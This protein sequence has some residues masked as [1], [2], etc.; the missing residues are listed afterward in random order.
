MITLFRTILIQR[1][2]IQNGS[3]SNLLKFMDNNTL[4]ELDAFIAEIVMGYKYTK[5]PDDFT[6][7]AIPQWCK[8]TSKGSPNWRV[9][10]SDPYIRKFAPENTPYDHSWKNFNPTIDHGLALKVL[11][12]CNLY[13]NESKLRSSIE[14][15]CVCGEHCISYRP[16]DIMVTGAT[17]PLIISQFAKELFQD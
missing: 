10:V 16:K 12:A 14:L 17:L 4:S 9:V 15:S 6:A 7:E 3:T 5:Q 2:S 13:I 1:T 8:H 11:A